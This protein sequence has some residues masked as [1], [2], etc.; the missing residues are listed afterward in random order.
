MDDWENTQVGRIDT[1]AALFKL[2]YGPGSRCGSRADGRSGLRLLRNL[3]FEF[4]SEFLQVFGDVHKL[5]SARI[6]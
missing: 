2:Y 6:I 5:K 4:F 3:H 1:E